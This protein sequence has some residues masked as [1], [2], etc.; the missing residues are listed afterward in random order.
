[1]PAK[2]K[3]QPHRKISVFK[4]VDHTPSRLTAATCP[5]N[6]TEA[7]EKFLRHGILPHFKLKNMSSESLDPFLKKK[8]NQVNFDYFKEAKCILDTVVKKFGDGC[9]YVAENYGERIDIVEGTET[10][11]GYLKENNCEGEMT[12]Y[13]TPQLECT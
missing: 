13:W 9:K 10:L 6:L 3:R 11:A 8:R 12:I 2:H 4:Q 1:M 5:V 7:K